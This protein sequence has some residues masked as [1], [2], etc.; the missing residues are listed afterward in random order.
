MY[1]APHKIQLS[2]PNYLSSNKLSVF[3][4]G[5]ILLVQKETLPNWIQELPSKDGQIILVKSDHSISTWLRRQPRHSHYFAASN[6][7]HYKECGTGN[8][9]VTV[10]NGP[11]ELL[12]QEHYGIS[13]PP[14]VYRVIRQ[15]EFHPKR[16]RFAAD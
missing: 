16:V 2:L 12:H 15:R 1:I 10:E 8:V 11:A 6:V 9:F 3:R 4:Q 5:D 13:V 7:R 14:G